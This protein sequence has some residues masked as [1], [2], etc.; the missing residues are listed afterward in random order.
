MPVR[1]AGPYLDSAVASILD[2]SFAD[3]EFVIRDDGS[4]DG[5][6]E[7]LRR[8][9]ALDPRIRLFEGASALGPAASSN[10]VVRHSSAPIV[11]RMDADDI[12]HPQRLQRQLAALEADGGAC[13]VASLWEGIDPDGVKVRPRDRW[14][15]TRAGPF[16]PFPHGS[17]M[18]RRQAFD[19]VG[20]YRAECNYWEDAD[21]YLRL[22]EVGRLLVLPEPLYLHRSS[23]LSTRLA[24]SPER[25]EQA[26][27]RMYR[28]LSGEVETDSGTTRRILPRVFVSLGSTRLWAGERTGMFARLWR[29]GE[30]GWNLHSLAVLGWAAWGG[31]APRSLRFALTLLI[32][33]RDHSVRRRFRDGEACAWRPTIGSARTRFAEASAIA[34]AP[35]VKPAA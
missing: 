31:L 2:Q 8:W 4:R 27:D 10:W 32:R 6:T 3:F 16:A 14:R 22:C 11:A 7:K 26:V 30:L 24:S 28:T 17:I 1:D 12:S 21:L 18:F 25:V 13:L 29:R 19:R 9:A 23:L 20:G 15:L 5:S 35:E 33:A 34:A